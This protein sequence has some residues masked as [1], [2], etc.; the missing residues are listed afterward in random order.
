MS[1]A[2]KA[3]AKMLNERSD[4]AIEV[5]T[6]LDEH[7]EIDIKEWKNIK[8][9]AY[10]S[11]GP[12]RYGFSPGLLLHM[13]RSNTDLVHVHGIWMFH[14]LAVL[15]WSKFSNKP[16]IVTPHGMMERWILARSRCIKL[17]VSKAYQD[18][19]LRQAAAFHILTVKEKAD[20]DSMVADKSSTLIPN[21]VALKSPPLSP[22]TWWT[23]DLSDRKIFM[24]FGRIHEKK[25]WRELCNAWAAA[26]ETDLHFSKTS[27]LVFCGW[28]DDATDFHE[29]ISSLHQRFGNVSFVGPQFADNKRASLRVAS[30]FILPSKSEGLPLV[31]LEAWAEGVPV[32]MTAACNLAIG[33][34]RG[35]AI[36][37]GESSEAI[38]KALKLV[39]TWSPEQYDAMAQ[40]A[41]KLIKEEF[42][43]ESAYAKTVQL[44]NNAL[45]S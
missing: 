26:C 27:H 41:K 23:N 15:L 10:R 42:S 2:V 33:F 21:F 44:Y 35:A 31:I 40:A 22:P 25:G 43:G 32:L 9:Y 34:E 29:C 1:E 30:V 8:I 16:Y 19:F 36:E 11:I 45:V 7:F 5:V 28:L 37:I 4:F 17:V 14:C 39:S 13:L 12:K 38:N 20:V 6:L 24:F 3:M 18:N